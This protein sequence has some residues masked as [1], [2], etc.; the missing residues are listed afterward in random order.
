MKQKIYIFGVVTAI[1]IFTGTLF[2]LNH[3]P[4]AGYL[5]IIGIAALVLGFLP[6]ALINHYK[7]QG[8]K[9]NLLLHIVTWLTCFVVFTSMLFKIQHWPYAGILLTVAIPFPYVV[10]LPVFI[11]TT[12]KNK[13]FSIYN[14]VY[15]LM[16]LAASS[17]LSALLALNVSAER[18]NDSYNLSKQYNQVGKVLDK[19]PANDS[20]SRIVLKIDEVLN[21]VDDYKNLIL[22]FEGISPGQ[23][24]YAGDLLRPDLRGA[25]LQGLSTTGN[26]KLGEKLDNS[27][28][29]LVKEIEN[30]PGCDDLTKA[31]PVILDLYPQGEDEPLLIW[32]NITNTLSWTLIYLDGMETNLKLIKASL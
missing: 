26:A 30:T 32:H 18:I 5:L 3:W 4:G 16:L 23:Y 19:L 22:K 10:F 2:K 25:A 31:I 13:N 20:D 14:T 12:A 24:K 6:L 27:L 7:A 15:V 17:V 21:V 29:D 9:Q 8:N 1:I 11:A 28:K